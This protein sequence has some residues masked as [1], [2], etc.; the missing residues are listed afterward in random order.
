M[1]KR[2]GLELRDENSENCFAITKF[3]NRY[4]GLRFDGINQVINCPK[5]AVQFFKRGEEDSN[6]CNNATVLMEE[7]SQK[8]ENILQLLDLELL[9]ESCN[10]PLVDNEFDEEIENYSKI[11][12]DISFMLNEQ[13]YAFSMED[14]Q[15]I[16]NI[17][18]ITNRIDYY[19]YMKGVISIRGEL[20]PIVD[21]N[22]YLF[23][24]DK[25][26]TSDSRIVILKTNPMCGVIV[27]RVVEVIK[28][29][30]NKLLEISDF[31]KNFLG[32][33]FSDIINLDENKN[34]IKITVNKLFDD[35]LKEHLEGCLNINGGGSNIDEESSH[36][37]AKK[38]TEKTSKILEDK[39]FIVFK[40]K[41]VYALEIENFQE[42]IKYPKDIIKIPGSKPHFEGMLNLRG[43]PVSVINMRKYFGLSNYEN[44]DEARI[45]LI[46]VG[47]STVGLVVDE[48]IEILKTL[49]EDIQDYPMSYI[50]RTAGNMSKYIEKVLKLEN[51]QR[52]YQL[53]MVL[54]IKDMMANLLEDN[55][56]LI[57]NFEQKEE[58]EEDVKNDSPEFNFFEKL[59]E[60]DKGDIAEK[61]SLAANTA[62][63]NVLNIK[64]D[65]LE[66][67][68]DLNIELKVEPKIKPELISEKNTELTEE[69]NK[70]SYLGE[71]LYN[72]LE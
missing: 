5:S 54:K 23:N 13:E 43:V 50:E 16:I 69:E 15:E 4:F 19:D 35:E 17:P 20:V 28:Y 63:E 30:E 71:D 18:E 33:V 72:Y 25:E 58:Y 68:T 65:E 44:F 57:N 2:F 24:L 56:K 27:D 22:K 47:D 7:T 42:I 61:I 38:T 34:I 40:M 66:D 60:A 31:D 62:K 59:G 53:L 6:C 48:I 46:K 14:V 10:L 21:L 11:F 1:R 37:F 67:K 39:T 55:N 29:E 51:S 9:F 70:D 26:L 64:N 45:I 49:N 36:A 32:E 3:K 12:H 41:E 8:A 52:N